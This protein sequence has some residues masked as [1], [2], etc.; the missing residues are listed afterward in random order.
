MIQRDEP[1]LGCLRAWRVLVQLLGALYWRL[2][3]NNPAL[4][5]LLDAGVSLHQ[6]FR[7]ICSRYCNFTELAARSIELFT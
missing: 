7:A 5:D 2:W 6:G 3:R 4:D 1:I